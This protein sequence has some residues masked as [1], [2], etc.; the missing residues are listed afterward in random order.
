[1]VS[2]EV[3]RDADI[4]LRDKAIYAH[5]TTYADSKTNEITVGVDRMAA[6]C[7]VDSSTIKRSLKSLKSKGIITR[8]SRG[9]NTTSLTILLK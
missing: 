9:I 6:E 5:L 4:S 1:M 3:I 2:N 7:G 8:I